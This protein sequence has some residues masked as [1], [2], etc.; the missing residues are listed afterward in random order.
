MELSDVGYKRDNL[1]IPAGESDTQAAHSVTVWQTHYKDT[2][3]FG[4]AEC[5]C[6]CANIVFFETREA[7]S[8]VP[9]W[10]G[11]NYH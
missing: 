5:V 9:G 2:G 10:F 11:E 6:V 1:E 8:R 4:L 7:L 3:F